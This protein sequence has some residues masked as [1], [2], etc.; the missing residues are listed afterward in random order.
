[1][2]LVIIIFSGCLGQSKPVSFYILK[3]IKDHKNIQPASKQIDT[4]GIGPIILAKYLDRPEIVTRLG[5]NR[6][7]INDFHQWMGPLKDNI[8][9]VLV[10]NF[11]TLLQPGRIVRFPWRKSTGVNR[12]IQLTIYRL[13]VNS[14]NVVLV[15][16]WWTGNPGNAST[17]NSHHSII[18]SPVQKDD[19]EARVSAINDTVNKLSVEIASTILQQ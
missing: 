5:D 11:A 9:N 19:Y 15:A 6:A 17:G 10:E 13:D 12:Q 8:S 1:M 16:D 14:K 4:L 3:P 18:Q 7:K 2:L